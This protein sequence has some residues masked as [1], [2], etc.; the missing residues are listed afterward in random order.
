MRFELEKRSER[1]LVMAWASPVIAVVATMITGG[2]I[3]AILGKPPLTALWVFF[4]EPFSSLWSLQEL[5]VKATPLIL[6]GVGLSVAYRA[7]VWNIGAEGQLTAGALAGSMVPI[8]FNSW[9]SPLTLVAMLVL[10]ILGGMI[11]ALVPALLKV[12]TGANEILVSLMMVYVA[13][14]LLDWLV[15]GPWRDPHGYNFPKSVSF[16]DWQ[17]MPTIGDGRLN[18]G[19]V[20][21]V[22]VAIALAVLMR[23]TIKGYEVRVMGEAPRAGRFAGFSA[24]RMVI[25]VFLLSGGLAG[26]AGVIEVASTVGQLQPNISPGYGFTAIIVAFLGRLDPIGVVVAALMLAVSYLGG[27]AAQIALGLS[28]KAARVF[29]GVLL[30]WVLACDTLILYRPRLVF[31]TTPEA[32]R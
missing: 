6:I 24:D 8:L 31:G 18:I 12:K 25:F 15:R 17:T 3:F 30:F 7:N 26:L 11:W 9:Q 27:E 2:L 19:I 13:Q 10:G 1:S 4:V 16:E 32:A 5:V 23:R 28:D 21:A 29:Q 14:L 22:V 20:I